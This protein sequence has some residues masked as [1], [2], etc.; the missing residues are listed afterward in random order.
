MLMYTLILQQPAAPQLTADLPP[1]TNTKIFYVAVETRRYNFP[2]LASA[3]LSADRRS[4]VKSKKIVF[5]FF[6]FLAIQKTGDP[7]I[8]KRILL[9][10]KI[11]ACATYFH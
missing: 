4:Q 3:A 11:L 9:V 5:F 2:N 7:K 6:S 10:Y 8:S 1:M